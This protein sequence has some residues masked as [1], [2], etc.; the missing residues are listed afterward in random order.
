MRGW[1]TGYGNR[2][3]AVEIERETEK[4]IWIDGRRRSKEGILWKV[5]TSWEKAHEYL[6]ER[7]RRRLKFATSEVE[8]SKQ[9]LKIIA[10]M[11]PP[12]ED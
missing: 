7:A 10:D 8:R 12:K 2:I 4:S 3:G 11:T 9:N 5:H 1:E 6:L